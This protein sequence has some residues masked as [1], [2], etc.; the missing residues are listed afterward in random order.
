MHHHTTKYS[1]DPAERNRISVF[2]W[3]PSSVKT[4]KFQDNSI[5]AHN[6][7]C[8]VAVSYC[9][10]VFTNVQIIDSV[11]PLRGPG[12]TICKIMFNRPLGRPR[13]RWEDNIKMDLQEV[14][15]GGRDWMELAQDRDRWR[16][17]VNT[18]MNFRVR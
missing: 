2:L 1:D 15:G 3:A 12:F 7:R 5:H 18:V 10:T 8:K 17:L 6:M 14:G 4:E 13:R 16:A 9:S 11:L